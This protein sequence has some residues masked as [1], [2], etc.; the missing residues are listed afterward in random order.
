MSDISSVF[1][2]AS[3]RRMLTPAERERANALQWVTQSGILITLTYHSGGV[4][5]GSNKES[6]RS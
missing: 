5:F 3:A 2:V 4:G 1:C 6:P